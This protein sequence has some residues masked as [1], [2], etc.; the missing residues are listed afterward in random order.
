[1]AEEN[2][3]GVQKET[4]PLLFVMGDA[5]PLCDPKALL[6]FAASTAGP[7][8]VVIVDGDHGFSIAA[9]PEAQRA[10][11][12]MQTLDDVGGAVARFSDRASAKR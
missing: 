11:A 3:P 1:M 9:L 4:R 12:L 2:Y 10:S 6:R 8:R 7:V 5:D